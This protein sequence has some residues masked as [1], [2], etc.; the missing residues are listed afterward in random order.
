MKHTH[1]QYLAVLTA[2]AAAAGCMTHAG[3]PAVDVTAAG[4]YDEWEDYCEQDGV[5]YASAD[6]ADPQL[7][8]RECTGTAQTVTIPE[9]VSTDSPTDPKVCVIGVE[10][11]GTAV[12]AG[13]GTCQRHLILPETVSWAYFY[14]FSAGS[15]TDDPANYYDLF[16]VLTFKNPSCDIR[17]PNIAQIK[18]LLEKDGLALT[19]RGL[20]GSTAETFAK[21]NGLTFERIQNTADSLNYE[22][23]GGGA[24]I[25][26]WDGEGTEL[27]VPAALGGLPVTA[28]GAGAFEESD[29]QRIT[30]PDSLKRIGDRAFFG[31]AGLKE[32]TIP[33]GCEEIGES[34]FEGCNLSAVRLP[35]SVTVLGKGAF[36][37]CGYMLSEVKLSAGLTEIPDKAF[38]GIGTLDSVEIPAGVKAIGSEA[39]DRVNR[40]IVLSPDCAFDENCMDP[41][42]SP[43][44]YGLCDSTAKAFA[45]AHSMIFTVLDS[46]ETVR[47]DYEQ[48][49]TFRV[50]D[51][52]A[53]VTGLSD[54]TPHLDIPAE[55]G[56]CPVAGIDADA[57]A[58]HYELVSVSIPETVTQIGSRAF[59]DCGLD[60]VRLPDGLTELADEVFCD[61]R[62]LRA[63]M[64]PNAVTRIGARA[65]RNAGITQITLPETLT[66]IGDETFLCTGITEITVPDSVKTLGEGVFSDCFALTAAKLPA[67]ITQISSRMFADCEA[68]TAYTVPETVTEIGESAFSCAGLESVT[69]PQSLKVIARAAFEST[70]LKAI[71]LPGNVT[72][73]GEYAFYDTA[74]CEITLPASVQT[75]ED[76]AFGAIADAVKLTVLNP[77]CD[78]HDCLSGCHYASCLCGA[79]DSTAQAYAAKLG[80]RFFDLNGNLL[81]E[82]SGQGYEEWDFTRVTGTTEWQTTETTTYTTVSELVTTDSAYSEIT[83]DVTVTTVTTVETEKPHIA[84]DEELCAWAVKDYQDKT[85]AEGIRAE[86]TSADG[87]TYEITLTDENGNVA[88]VYTVDPATGT[89][90]DSADKPVNLPQTGNNRLTNLLLAVAAVLLSGFGWLMLKSSGIIRRKKDSNR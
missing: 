59:A 13:E 22:E 4:W 65:F 16:T 45:A 5:R 6:S 78:L 71:T 74:L 61:C 7:V 54:S 19:V 42:S 28:I 49:L 32:I 35:D 83:E 51:G 75:A 29:L 76:N 67:G 33:D 80:I 50:Q 87:S 77:D 46:G 68:L 52:K 11:D 69:L 56:G 86:I 82:G 72:Q 34:A 21:E 70:P 66:E 79:P 38:C 17:I 53:Y 8:V 43:T 73:I 40:L 84:S 64:L 26:G 47:P 63:V 37:V 62:S 9:Y 58:E 57:F 10:Y 88:E 2:L 14:D 20:A 30:L 31:C 12:K 55:Y 60:A 1:R 39:F 41:F 24:V 90:K 89:G 44:V 27:T 36:A 15:M 48:N 18:A 25:T 85:G 3:A 81:S 23:R